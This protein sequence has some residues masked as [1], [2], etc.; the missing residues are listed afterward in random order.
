LIARV[1]GR[2]EGPALLLNGHLDAHIAP[3]WTHDP[4]SPHV[5]DGRFYGAAVTDMLGGLAAMAAAVEAAASVPPL[6]GDLVL[7]A[8]M[9]HDGNGLGVKYAL[10]SEFDWPRYG[11][12]GEPSSLMIH[13]ANGGA[14]KFEITVRGRTAHISRKQEGID[15]LAAAAGVYDKVQSLVP[16][17]TPHPRLPDLPRV[18]VGELQ[19]GTAPAAVAD[20]AVLR[21]DVRTVPGMTRASLRADLQRIIQSVVGEPNEVTL[22]FT[23]VH[24]TFIGPT[25]GRLVTAL[26]AAHE[27]VRGE[28]AIM[29][30]GLPGQA[31]VT[32]AADM[33]AAGIETVVYGPCDWHF[34]PDESVDVDEL[35][36][37][38][39]VYLATAALLGDNATSS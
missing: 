5:E 35:A 3:G 14:M 28:A 7:L 12:N 38:A 23:A 25:S 22:R 31:F 33:A 10:A 36:D 30:V 24:R 18:L 20:Q 21:G 32:D 1:R 15:A 29:P 16:T 9:H 8:S 26:K 6:P 37:A 4:Y 13:T 2:G 19:A 27:A 39:R 34:A 11:I 17:H